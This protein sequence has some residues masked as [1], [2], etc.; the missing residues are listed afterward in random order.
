MGL[1][2]NWWF[3]YTNSG[4]SCRNFPNENGNRKYGRENTPAKFVY[5]PTRFSFFSRFPVFPA[6]TIYDRFRRQM[7][8]IGMGFSR[9]RY[10][11]G[12]VCLSPEGSAT[13][14]PAPVSSSLLCWPNNSLSP[15]TILIGL[16]QPNLQRRGPNNQ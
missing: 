13:R 15:E 8:P 11:V 16:L 2:L 4:I 14:G 6:V 5:V 12:Q 7:V 1:R 10:C 9:P 3:R